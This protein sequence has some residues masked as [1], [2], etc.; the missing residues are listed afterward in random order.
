[1]FEGA[2]EHGAEEDLWLEGKKLV[3][4]GHRVSDLLKFI[5][6]QILLRCLLW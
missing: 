1:M 2:R 5:Y 6:L 4:A 3:E